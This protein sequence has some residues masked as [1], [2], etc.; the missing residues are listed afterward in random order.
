[1]WLFD[2]AQGLESQK[3]LFEPG[4]ITHGADEGGEFT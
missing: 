4:V 1:M 3:K 2:T